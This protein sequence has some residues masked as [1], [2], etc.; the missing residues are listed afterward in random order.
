MQSPPMLIMYRLPS[1]DADPSG[2][3]WSGAASHMPVNGGS[4]QIFSVTILLYNVTLIQQVRLEL[5]LNWLHH[6]RSC[7]CA[8][9]H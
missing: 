8:T 9:D 2:L 3:E 4:S 5:H 6:Y 1:S 7:T